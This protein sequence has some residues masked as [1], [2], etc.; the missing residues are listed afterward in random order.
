M[1]KTSN[2][3]VS[4]SE[5]ELVSRSGGSVSSGEKDDNS[6]ASSEGEGSG[7]AESGEGAN[8]TDQSVEEEEE[9]EGEEHQVEH[10]EEDGDV[11]AENGEFM[12]LS[13]EDQTILHEHLAIYRV[14]AKAKRP[15]VAQ[16]CAKLITSRRREANQA[17]SKRE[18]KAL[19]HV[20]KDWFDAQTPRTTVKGAVGKVWNTR[21]VLQ[22]E[23]AEEIKEVRDKMTKKWE[24]SAEGRKA[25]KSERANKQI[26]FYGNATTEI[27][28]A[29]PEEERR[30]YEKMAREWTLEGPSM[31]EQQRS[32]KN[33]MK[34]ADAFAIRC[35]SRMNVRLF[36]FASYLDE[37]G[38]LVSMPMDFTQVVGETS[39]TA[40]YKQLIETSELTAAWDKWSKKELTSSHRQTTRATG[41]HIRPASKAL[42]VLQKN[43]YSE[44]ILPDPRE[45]PLG[46][47]PKDHLTR[48]FRTFMVMSYAVAMG[49]ADDGTRAVVPWS[50]LTADPKSFIAEEHLPSKY[51]EHMK[52]DP[53]T[54]RLTTLRS[55]LT[56]WWD[57][58][59]D[60]SR[61]RVVDKPAFE[62]HSYWDPTL[63]KS[64]PR[65]PRVQYIDPEPSGEEGGQ[66]SPRPRK[67]QPKK[68]KIPP[69]GNRPRTRSTS[70][71]P[72][73]QDS[74][75][76][77]RTRSSSRASETLNTRSPS[78]GKGSSSKSKGPE[79]GGAAGGKSS[80][81]NA[82]KAN[83]SKAGGSKAEGS[84]S[85]AVK[86]DGSKA[87]GSKAEG[88]KSKA[89]KADG[90]KAG[91]SKAQ[92]SK[93]KAEGS[94]SKAGKEG[95]SKA[96]GSKSKAG[97]EGGSKAEGSKSKAGK[98]DG[99]K[100]GGSK[101]EGSKSKTAKADGSKSKLGKGGLKA[102]GSKVKVGKAKAP[103]EE[104]SKSKSSRT[105]GGK[106]EASGDRG[107]SR[108]QDR[109]PSRSCSPQRGR[110][111]SILRGPNTDRPRRRAQSVT[112]APSDSH[113]S[114]SRGRGRSPSRRGRS[115]SGSRGSR[116]PSSAPSDQDDGNRSGDGSRDS[117]VKGKQRATVEDEAR[118]AEEEELE[119]LRMQDADTDLDH[120]MEEETH[121]AIPTPTHNIS[122]R[123]PP[124]S[125]SR[126]YQ[127]APPHVPTR[128]SPSKPRNPAPS[129]S[130][131]RS[132]NKPV[133][134]VFP[135]HPG[136]ERGRQSKSPRKRR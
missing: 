114:S 109:S 90:S 6:E 57:R 113:E 34:D 21:G 92:G 81:S 29:L 116:Q 126:R 40:R 25:T 124:L 2:T 119:A 61:R 69:R 53:S 80:K 50:K 8:D 70:R 123:L 12:T 35:Y 78:N 27:L 74:S 55:L 56:F 3:D 97:K 71:R 130:S 127:P 102:E 136:L 31:E 134:S 30:R 101:A 67:Q 18:S 45:V 84:K 24:R 65:V 58:Q 115:P 86:A 39:F 128:N 37:R 125:P 62:F 117:S 60:F 10:E 4:T 82:G 7:N 85:K 19:P 36:M 48:L 132:P 133:S 41:E 98:A 129:I 47:R 99:S 49:T 68:S 110:S 73:S 93:S 14:S 118:W 54:W 105:K 52:L 46:I 107:R 112:W 64:V 120:D 131:Q 106:P 103:K 16:N 22:V 122:L 75:I 11:Q 9:G 95:G 89:A 104:E 44:P 33:F 5:E 111:R 13:P 83:G 91:G 17:L 43:L 121:V 42:L 100:A 66:E 26:G 15:S 88:S 87:G 32:S 1:T 38:D 59:A 79:A 72:A 20:L 23:L 51:H 63:K 135:P 108:A 28:E 77:S 76:A 96:E 94:K